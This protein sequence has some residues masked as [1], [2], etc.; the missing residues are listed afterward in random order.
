MTY[1]ARITEDARAF[2][3]KMFPGYESDFLRTDPEFIERFDNFAFDEVV[4]QVQ[5]DDETR[6]LG[7]L[8]TLLGCQGIDEYCAMLPAALRNGITPVQAKEVVYQAVAYLG[9]GR[10]FPFLKATNEILEAQD[11][12]LPLPERATT[13]PERK[14]RMAAG[15]Q[16][17]VDIFGESM[18]D[19]KSKGNPD[20]PWINEWLVDN[21]FG[22]WYT[23]GGL[24]LKQRELVTF[25]YIAAQGG[26]DAQLRGHAGANLSVGNSRELLIRVVSSNL[27]FIGYP[28]TLNALAALDAVAQDG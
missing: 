17:Q 9:I 1:E 10:V 14:S 24:D 2:H 15:E 19:Y 7:W 5:L 12:Q 13:K 8:A 18:R 4:T 20:Y 23:R 6:Y 11:T 21:C 3:E 28:R 26:C 25:C 16:A 27:P 22:D